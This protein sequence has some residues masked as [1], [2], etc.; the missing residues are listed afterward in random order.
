VFQK[1]DGANGRGKPSL[2]SAAVVAEA[3]ARATTSPAAETAARRY[4][5]RL[6][7]H[8]SASVNVRAAAAPTRRPPRKTQ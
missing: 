5:Y 4:P 1:L 8:S 2:G 3:A 7:G 6:S